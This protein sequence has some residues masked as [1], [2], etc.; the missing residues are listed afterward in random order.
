MTPIHI[1][2]Y[3][4]LDLAFH[5][6]DHEQ[7][8]WW[9]QA[10]PVLG[11]LM[12]HSNYNISKQYQYLTFFAHH[13]IPL[14]GPSPNS[15]T[16]DHQHGM[17]PLEISQTFQESGITIRLMF[18]P[19]SY[20]G[21]GSTKDSFGGLVTQEV[22]ARLGQ[23]SGVELD[24]QLYYE[25]MSPLAL[26]KKEEE[27]I[28][29]SGCY[30]NLP[31][32]FKVQNLVGIQLS[33]SGEI[34]IKVDWLL[35]AKSMISKTPVSELT[36]QAIRKLDQ[37]KGI[38]PGLRH[39]EEY[40]KAI[41]LP[42]ASPSIF[43]PT[44]FGAMTCHLVDKARTR[45]K[46]YTCIRLLRFEHVA[47]IWTLGG[48]LKDYPGIIRGLEILHQLW[49]IL[50]I[51]EGYHHPPF[52]NPLLM[53]DEDPDTSSAIN[54][55]AS[56]VPQFFDDE[57]I[58]INFEIRP[59]DPCPQPKVYFTLSYLT[60]SR[61]VDAVVALFRKLGWEREASRYKEN[62][63][64]YFPASDLGRTPGFHQ[65]LSFSY[66]DKTGPYTSVYY[67]RIGG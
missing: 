67:C 58:F 44:D 50:P 52:V 31:P 45:L 26:T 51:T 61:V 16:T 34:A 3:E 36:F 42:P 35:A 48:R 9:K 54:K 13:I 32:P 63:K 56:T 33:R 59:R 49:A 40:F 64:K 62:F 47:D 66:S 24:P 6:D 25:L 28:L 39:I 17:H 21:S 14:L 19:K 27:D 8:N 53:K 10:A 7:H 30:D 22:L 37:G 2:P 1:T 20:S 46:I 60:D 43:Q 15:S 65:F 4:T 5:F 11:E 18:E 12:L 29:N 23:V 55:V 57:L 38:F 41:N